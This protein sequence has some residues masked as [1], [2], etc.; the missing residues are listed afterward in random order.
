MPR[1]SIPA[2]GPCATRWLAPRPRPCARRF[3]ECAA[4][5]NMKRRHKLPTKPASSPRPQIRQAA[6]RAC[7]D[8]R[9]IPQSS[10][11]G[12][13]HVEPVGL[14][15]WPKFAAK[16]C[17]PAHRDLLACGR[18]SD[19]IPRPTEKERDRIPDWPHPESRRREHSRR[20]RQSHSIA[21]FPCRRWRRSNVCQRCLAC[22]NIFGPSLHS[23]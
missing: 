7:A 1:G 5:R 13:S 20:R 21:E 9:R 14:D 15:N 16:S 6:P 23:P 11:S 8:R 2:A 19:A 4:P 3:P 22:P 18:S 17:R 10:P 12:S